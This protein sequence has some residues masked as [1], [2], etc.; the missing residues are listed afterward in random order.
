MPANNI[1]AGMARSYTSNIV[2]FFNEN[3]KILVLYREFNIA[4]RMECAL[5][6]C[7]CFEREWN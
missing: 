3:G 1:F 6:F 4:G 5:H 7:C 2:I